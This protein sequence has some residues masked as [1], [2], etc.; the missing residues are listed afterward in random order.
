VIFQLLVCTTATLA[1]QSIVLVSYL[2]VCVT[3]S[4]CQSVCPQQLKSY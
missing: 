3:V 1:K 2:P 4:V